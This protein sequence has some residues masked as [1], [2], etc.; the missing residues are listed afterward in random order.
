MNLPREVRAALMAGNRRIV[1]QLVADRR[2]GVLASRPLLHG[3][4]ALEKWIALADAAERAK[5][6]TAARF[7]RLVAVPPAIEGEL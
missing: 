3:A 4:R 7:G 6:V 5:R 1:L 2:M